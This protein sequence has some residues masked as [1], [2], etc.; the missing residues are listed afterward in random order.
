MTEEQW[1][2][3]MRILNDLEDKIVEIVERIDIGI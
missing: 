2:E 1:E 3:A